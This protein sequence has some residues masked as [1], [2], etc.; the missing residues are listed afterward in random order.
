MSLTGIKESLELAKIPLEQVTI[1]YLYP[2]GDGLLFMNTRT[3]GIFPLSYEHVGQAWKLLPPNTRCEMLRDLTTDTVLYFEP[4]AEVELVVANT[5]PNDVPGMATATVIN[6][7]KV[8]VPNT[9]CAGTRIRIN[10]ASGEY[11]GH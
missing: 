5:E 9:V 8:E 3:L 2:E 10:P 4:P 1:E 7:V 11:L 6:K